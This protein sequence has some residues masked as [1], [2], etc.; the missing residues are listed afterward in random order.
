MFKPIKGGSVE[1]IKV[2][3]W[4]QTIEYRC[5]VPPVGYGI[6]VATGE[7]EKTDILKRSNKKSEQKFERIPLPDWWDRKRAEEKSKQRYDPKYTDQ[8]CEK[9]RK[10]EWG[11]RLRGVWFWNNGELVYIT[12]EHW[13]FLNW[14][15]FQTKWMDY[16]NPNR[17]F[18]YIWCLCEEDPNSLGLIE[19]TKRKEGKTARLGCIVYERTSRRMGKHAGIQ[20]KTDDDADEVFAKAVIQPWQSLPD[21]YRP[22][23]DKSQGTVPQEKLRF[24]KTSV[25][26]AKADEDTGEEELQSW[27]DFK[28]RKVEAYDGPELDTYGSDEAGKLKDVSIWERHDT[29]RY[30]SEVDGEFIG[31]QLYTTTVEEME[32]GGGE[33]LKL[34]NDSNPLERDENGRTKSGMY[35]YMLPAYETMYYDDYG[36]PDIARGMQYFMNIRASKANDE[37]ALM[38]HI[39]KNPFTLAEAFKI[40]GDK[41]HYNAY[42]LN[43]RRAVI[44]AIRDLTKRGNLIWKDGII[45]GEVIWEDSPNG[46]WE[47]SWLPDPKD[48]NKV[49]KLSGLWMP[50]GTHLFIS[51][52]DTYDHK[53]TEDSRNSMAA[54][55]VKRRS[56]FGVG[57][58]AKK[59]FFKYH[60]R[61]AMPEMVYEDMILQCVFFGCQINCENNKPGVLRY[62]ERRGYRNFLLHLPG[63]KE[64]GIASTQEHKREASL[65]VESHIE[66]H[67]HTYDFVDQI[68]QLLEFNIDKTEKYDLVMAMLWTEYGDNYRYQES[69]EQ[70]EELLEVDDLMNSYN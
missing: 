18:F 20:S 58:I 31:K 33:F 14:W 27:I 51:G 3:F 59:Y 64:P 2:D 63:K 15:K 26:G 11:R 54:S 48:T 50:K 8:D 12:G 21:L 61:P 67:I 41:C 28:N 45:D 23:W 40:D 55:W 1:V 47:A 9:F 35:I 22:L 37:R 36:N 62:F 49:D 70:K 29:V 68:D 16:R 30:C 25:R 56:S 46:R 65:M 6:N 44:L 32:S 57:G 39:R 38:S 53:S 66:Q 69:E 4:G 13:F 5:H 19:V 42:K 24:F 60:F 7:L 52:S 17:K 43:E 10:E 34:V